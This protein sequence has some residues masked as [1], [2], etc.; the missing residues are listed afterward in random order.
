[1]MYDNDPLFP[2]SDS[3]TS[4]APFSTGLSRRYEDLNQG[5]DLGSASCA[6]VSTLG[7][8]SSATSSG[9]GDAGEEVGEEE[10]EGLN[11]AY[12]I[13]EFFKLEEFENK[14][15]EATNARDPVFAHESP[16]RLAPR[17]QVVVTSH[18]VAF[19]TSQRPNVRSPD[20]P[21]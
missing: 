1:M 17:D 5:L 18:Y 2:L 19:K 9:G 12:D 11:R 15:S 8:A 16:P 4:P 13:T 7:D 21:R 20:S 14:A 3:L 6:A 10:E